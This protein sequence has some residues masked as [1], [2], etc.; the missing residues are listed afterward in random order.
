M[1]TPL[2]TKSI[3][4][5]LGSRIAAVMT[6]LQ[7]VTESTRRATN[8]THTLNAYIERAN[9]VQAVCFV[10]RSIDHP[11]FH[12]ASSGTRARWIRRLEAKIENWIGESIGTDEICYL[13]N[14]TCTKHLFPASDETRTRWRSVAALRIHQLETTM[15]ENRTDTERATFIVKLKDAEVIISARALRFVD[16]IQPLAKNITAGEGGEFNAQQRESIDA[17]IEK[18]GQSV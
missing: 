8:A 18:H 5:E 6:G 15:N 9:T 10:R 14:A 4:V 11:N 13:L 3:S 17:L 1:I 7:E 2:A 12:G 16:A